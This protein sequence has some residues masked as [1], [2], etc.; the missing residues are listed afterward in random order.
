MF[1]DND[2]APEETLTAMD[3]GFLLWVQERLADGRYVGYVMEE[4]GEALASAGIFFADFPPHY[5][6]TAAGRPYLL[7]FYTAPEGRGRG[8]AN[9]MLGICVE[10]CRTRGYKTI[11]LHASPFGRPIYEKFGFEGT[12]EMML[13]F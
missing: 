9:A 13:R 2:F 4:E 12:N 8:F 10:E 7:N 3:A 1:A 6:Q 5:L 11:V